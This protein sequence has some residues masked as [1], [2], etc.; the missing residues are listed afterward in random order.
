MWRQIEHI[1]DDLHETLLAV[2]STVDRNPGD[3][4]ARDLEKRLTD[5]LGRLDQVVE[6]AA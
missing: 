1:A 3:V 5:I 4:Q 6:Q 2:K